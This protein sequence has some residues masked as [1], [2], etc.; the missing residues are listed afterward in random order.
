MTFGV[1]GF[2]LSSQNLSVTSFS[3]VFRRTR[4]E[5]VKIWP[6]NVISNQVKSTNDY[7][8]EQQQ[9]QTKVTLER[10]LAKSFDLKLENKSYDRI[11]ETFWALN[12]K[13]SHTKQL[14]VVELMILMP[15]RDM[16]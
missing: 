12:G 8:Q 9:Q 11:F 15:S 7:R 3:A 6:D 10:L 14:V 5:P 1:S 16:K 13:F 2:R 4:R